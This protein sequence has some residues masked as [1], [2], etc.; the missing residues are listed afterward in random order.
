[1]VVMKTGDVAAFK[2]LIEA[3]AGRLPVN[4]LAAVV[5]TPDVVED[6]EYL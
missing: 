2:A 1:M 3:V 4:L 5:D 6:L